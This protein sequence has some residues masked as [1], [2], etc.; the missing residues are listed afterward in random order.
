MAT[1]DARPGPER[2]R[3]AAVAYGA[4]RDPR[5][6]VAVASAAP[7]VADSDL[8]QAI[9]EIGELAPDLLPSFVD[10]AAVGPNRSRV[11][12]DLLRRLGAADEADAVARRAGIALP[13]LKIA[14]ATSQL[15][16]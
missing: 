1:F 3:A 4:F 8:A 16:G 13:I 11:I 2:A 9:V 15:S 12:A 10:A 5:A 7:A 14:A 6:V